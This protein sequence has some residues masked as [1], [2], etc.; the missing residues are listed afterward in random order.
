M[1][2]EALDP[3]RDRRLASR[4]TP[5]QAE[6]LAVLLASDDAAYLADAGATIDRVLLTG[7]VASPRRPDEP[8][9]ATTIRGSGAPSVLLLQASET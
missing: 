1:R 4:P 7:L 9:D 6:A 8:T 2:T 5:K 3:K